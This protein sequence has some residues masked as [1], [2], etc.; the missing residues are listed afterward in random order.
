MKK[1]ILS[2]LAVAATIVSCS[3]KEEGYTINGKFAD[4]KEG[5]VY[6]EFTDGDKTITDSTQIKDGNFTFKG[7]LEEP[8]LYSIKLNKAQNGAQFLLDNEDITFEAK[9]DSL[10]FAKVSGATQDSIYKSFYEN[11]YKK[12]AALMEPYYKTDDS[13]TQSGKVKLTP[14]QEIM[15]NKRWENIRKFVDDVTGKF[16]VSHKDKLAA[17]LIINERVAT[18]GSPE[19]V[20]KYYDVL[21]PEIQKSFYGKKIKNTIEINEKTAVGVM[22]PLFSQADVSGKIVKLSDYKGKYVLVDFW[23]SWCGPCREENPNV[24]LAYNTYHDKGFEILGVS[25]DDRKKDWEKAIEKDGLTWTHVSDLKGWENEVAGLYG[26]NAVPTNYLIGPDGKIVAKNL[27][28]AEL[29]SKL[30]EIFNKS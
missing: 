26:V 18:S 10:F 24:V 27:R 23:A 6:L 8:L 1:L 3:N 17:A 30:K 15:L 16:I 14:S 28:K 29:Q 5:T 4:I 13:L 20:K 21:T 22:A 9:K 19:K 2:G 7:K 12:I 11:E 25:L